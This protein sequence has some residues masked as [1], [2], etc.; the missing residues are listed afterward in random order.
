MMDKMDYVNHYVVTARFKEEGSMI[1]K[2]M[3]TTHD[4]KEAQEYNVSTYEAPWEVWIE[5]YMLNGRCE[6]VD[7]KEPQVLFPQ[8]G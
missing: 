8:I 3:L 5:H 7:M 4:L 1:E 6:V 2:V